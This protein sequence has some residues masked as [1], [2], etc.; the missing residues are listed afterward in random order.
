MKNL[1]RTA[2]LAV[3][4]ALDLW[5]LTRERTLE[6]RMLTP[7]RSVKQDEGGA[8]RAVLL[9][10]VAEDGE[11]VMPAG[12]LVHGRIG[13]VQP[14]GFG[15]RRERASVEVSFTG[16]EAPD[17]IHTPVSTR[18]LRVDNAREQVDAQG[19]IRGILAA[20]NAMGLVRGIW[21][22]PDSRM[23]VRAPLGLTGACGTAWSRF[24]LGPHGA[25][26]L[27]GTKLLLT[28]LPEPE[29]HL[30][31]GTELSLGLRSDLPARRWGQLPPYAGFDDSLALFLTEQPS[32]IRK[33]D[34]TTAGDLI[35]LALIGR[36]ELVE[37][38]FAAAG[39]FEAEALTARSFGRAYQAF[40][41][42][43]GFPTAPVSK[44]HYEGRPP[45]LVFQ[46]SLNS[47]AKRHH[48]RLW[49]AA[50]PAGEEIWLGAAT[51]DVGVA[52]NH[53]RFTLTHRIDP[54]LDRERDKV[55]ADL[56]FAGAIAGLAPLARA[57]IPAAGARTDGALTVALLQAAETSVPIE[58]ASPASKISLPKRAVRRAV[59]ETKYYL[60]R[61]N[62]PYW[63]YLAARTMAGKRNR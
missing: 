33:P 43:Q 24:A 16:W 50:G 37:Q 13:R 41:S 39:W 51:H 40:V 54:G 12:T 58:A 27:I 62:A 34:G 45:D 1:L 55:I 52:F 46:K 53:R 8:I 15:I 30:P 44:L 25:V 47:I 17:G 57:V 23:I 22:R 60:L 38:A 20:K 18:L 61:D 31:A 21:I 6:V 59:L 4:P 14:V 11:V 3:I 35:N 7:I 49:R 32:Q 36:R 63:S 10:P 5:G 42:R 9:R 2:T 48:I 26:G 28:R 19:R 56:Q 29:I